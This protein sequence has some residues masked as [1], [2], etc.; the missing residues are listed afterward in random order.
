HTKS[1]G[2]RHTRTNTG[3]CT[4]TVGRSGNTI[5]T[6]SGAA[7]RDLPRHAAVD[8]GNAADQSGIQ[9][10][11][12]S[13]LRCSPHPLAGLRPAAGRTDAESAFWYISL[14][15]DAPDPSLCSSVFLCVLLWL[16]DVSDHEAEGR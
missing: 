10:R 15:Q 12:R 16:Q 5:A 8:E 3:T 1:D 11:G 9:H 14:A 13:D 7:S 2:H 6:Y 4:R